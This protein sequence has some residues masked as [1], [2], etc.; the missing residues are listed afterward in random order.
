[1]EEIDK[2]TLREV[3]FEYEREMGRNGGWSFENG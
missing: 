2:F 1:M 3:D